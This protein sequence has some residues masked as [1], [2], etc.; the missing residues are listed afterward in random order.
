MYA[1]LTREIAETFPDWIPCCR[2]LISLEQSG[3][4]IVFEFSFHSSMNLVYGSVVGKIG[5]YRFLGDKIKTKYCGIDRFLNSN[6][7]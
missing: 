4:W 3:P 1:L 2:S 6:V 7:S 5:D